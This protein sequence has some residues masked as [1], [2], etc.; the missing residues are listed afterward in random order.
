MDGLTKDVKKLTIDVTGMHCPNCEH[1][2]ERRISKIPGVVGTIA[3]ERKGSTKIFYLGELDFE[4]V[5]RALNDEGYGA[6]LSPDESGLQ[7]RNSARDYAQIAGV[8]ALLIGLALFVQ[9]LRLVPQGFSI[10][11]NTGYGL[12]FLIGL[13]ASVTSCMAVTGGLLVALAAKY[14]EASPEAAAWRRFRPHLAFNAGRLVSYAL[15]GGAVGALGSALTLTPAAT[16]ALILAASAVMI[17]LGL[18]MLRLLPGFGSL[19]PKGVTHR[20]HDFAERNSGS[21]SF[22]LGA[23]TF[24]LPCGFTQALQLYVL[25]KGSLTVGALTMLAFALGT[26]PALLSLSALSSFAR[27]VFQKHF[28]RFAGAAVIVLGVLNIQYGF[29][30][31]GSNLG[32][33]AA[34]PQVAQAIPPVTGGKQI[35]EMKIDGYDYI[36]NRFT[37]QQGVPVEW[38]IDARKAAGC[39][40]ILLSRSLGIEKFLS[41][42]ETN[43]IAFTPKAAG[44]YSFN[45]GMGMMTPNSQFTVIADPAAV[46]PGAE[47]I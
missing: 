37:V 23:L 26:L 42:T 25:A 27:G 3:S 15:L 40:R 35:V 7:G 14:N 36:P 24:F 30:L 39:G 31:A 2:I 29:V 34:T 32:P 45:C 9:H 20:I 33:A 5:R 13:A 1:V 16:S 47:K 11:E 44:Q 17:V 38:R 6:S 21:G 8:F 10:S 28:L 41:A 19:L 18:Q 46:P 43:V 4:A 12:A 22:L